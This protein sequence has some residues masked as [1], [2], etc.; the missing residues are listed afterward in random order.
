MNTDHV[1]QQQ[2]ARGMTFSCSIRI[3]TRRAKEFPATSRHSPAIMEGDAPQSRLRSQ[4][5]HRPGAWSAKWGSSNSV[6]KDIEVGSGARG[7][8]RTADTVIFSRMLYQLS[9]PGTGSSAGRPPDGGVP[10]GV[11]PVRCPAHNRHFFATLHR[12]VG[13]ARDSLRPAIAAGHGRGRQARKKGEFQAA[14]L[15]RRWGRKRA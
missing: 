14:R 8:S 2:G 9:Y 3:D 11:N 6:E 4:G 7:R 10:I 13:Q 12:P 15:R 5:H 1:V